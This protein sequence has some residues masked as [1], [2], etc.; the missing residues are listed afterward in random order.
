MTEF[1][2]DLTDGGSGHRPGSNRLSETV[3]EGVPVTREERLQILGKKLA[4]AL[5]IPVDAFNRRTRSESVE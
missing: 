5:N 1:F 3:N 4:E 2:H